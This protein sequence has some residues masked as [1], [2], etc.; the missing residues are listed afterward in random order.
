M[1]VILYF[2]NLYFFFSTPLHRCANIY[3]SF[4]KQCFS[5]QPSFALS[6]NCECVRFSSGKGNY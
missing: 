5:G 1:S 6:T 3:L 2:A 4:Y